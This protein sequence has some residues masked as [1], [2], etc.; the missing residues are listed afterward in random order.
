MENLHIQLMAIP[1][2]RVAADNRRQMWWGIGGVLAL[3]VSPITLLC[4]LPVGVWPAIGATAFTLMLAGF[5]AFIGAVTGVVISPRLDDDAMEKETRK[6]ATQKLKVGEGGKPIES[7]GTGIE[8][9]TCL[10]PKFV[11][12]CPCSKDA[13]IR[14]KNWSY[15][16]LWRK[17]ISV[18]R[19]ITG[20]EGYAVLTEND[21]GHL[22]FPALV[23]GTSKDH[24]T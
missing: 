1:A 5:L 3:V 7:E 4:M 10:H 18:E 24:R 23:P 9:H 20:W 17:H 13:P 19:L 21:E 11:W 8:W 12:V 22:R 15:S 2:R 14:D 6:C 16:L